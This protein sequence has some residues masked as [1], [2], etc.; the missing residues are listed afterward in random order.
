M[1]GTPEL[2]VERL[3]A[4]GTRAETLRA[5]AGGVNV[6]EWDGLRWL[7]SGGRAVQAVMATAEPS[8]P[9]LPATVA[10]LGALLLVPRP[11]SVLNLGLGGACLERFLARHVPTA[12]LHAVESS[13]AV[14]ALAREHFGVPD[15]VTL[16]LQTADNY[17]AESGARFELVLC[18]L[19]EGER[20]APCV[21]QPGF[22]QALAA[23]TSPAGA[24]ALN[25][26]PRS[27][28]ELLEIL[29]PLRQVAPWVM[30]SAVPGC[31]NVCVLA[32]RQP[33][34]SAADLA[35]RAAALEAR[36]GLGFGAVAARL[37]AL[38]PP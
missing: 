8:L 9:C 22:L 30:L 23:R 31:G 26:S 13:A 6:R 5:R 32:A 11:A 18:D 24:V 2:L 15:T 1:S 25:L 7:E 37:N 12:A 35:T 21:G 17:L 4:L 28:S 33:P 29:L 36:S 34:P 3:L 16:S 10:L 27:E 20:H 14:L 38:P 19:F